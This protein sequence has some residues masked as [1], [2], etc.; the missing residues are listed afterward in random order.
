MP[1]WMPGLNFTLNQVKPVSIPTNT[2]KINLFMVD[3]WEYVT[4]Y[5]IALHF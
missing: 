3:I 4:L 5:L 1:D 2:K